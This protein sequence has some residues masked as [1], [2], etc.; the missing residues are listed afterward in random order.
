MPNFK[1]YNQNQ[2]MLLPPRLAD[3]LPAKHIAF[4]I[5]DV[6]ENM[7]LSA[8][9]NTYSSNGSPAYDPGMMVKVMFYGYTQGIRSSRKIE[10]RLRE[11]IAFRYLSASQTPDHGTISL[12]R[13]N[14]LLN[15][16]EIFPQIVALSD[17]LG[18]IDPADISIDGTKLKANASK[19]N[20]FDREEIGKLREKFG[21]MLEEAEEIDAEE[22][23]LYGENQ[24]YNEAQGDMADSEKRKKIIKERLEKLKK[25]EQ[26]IDGKQ[27]GAKSKE[28]KELKK[29]ATSNTTDPDANL[30]E[31]KDGSFKMGYN[32][33][34]T[35]SRQVITAYGLNG[36]SSD[37]GCLKE[38][39]EENDRNT[40]R[41]TETLKADAGYFSQNNLEYCQSRKI[42]TYCPD[43]RKAVEERQERKGEIPEYD[44]RNFRYDSEADEYVCP[45][46]KR[47]SS[48]GSNRH[49]AKV[50]MAREC[51]CGTCPA[52]AEC[53]KGKRRIVNFN[54]RLDKIVKDM[55]MK[56][57]GEKGK[58][59]YLERMSEIEPV[60]GNL[61][62]NQQ[63]THF[64]CR[65]KPRALIELGLA[66]TAHNL[67]KIFNWIS[68]NG[69]SRDEI[70]WNGLMRLRTAC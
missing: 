67:V 26:A 1:P 45:K 55:R 49:G 33:Q 68:K 27:A 3:C 28:E 19:K 63:F 23:R 47:L 43:D 38:M 9:E 17:G 22:D 31:M 54:S 15:L 69:K 58:R 51:E 50:Y 14:H 64:L 37:K 65:G 32:A 5:N 8:V 36:D 39:V 18:M 11:D 40:G 60:I 29:N 35:A 24:G 56:L 7:D 10:A 52:K 25:A 30:M 46:G 13:K 21:K 48:R 2:A 34:F 70:Q 57:N 44:R 61:K 6:V 20:L 53:T 59:K 42:D 66:S 16:R 41:K 12:F 62:H 4:I